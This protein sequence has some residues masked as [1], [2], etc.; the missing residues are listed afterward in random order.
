[1][2]AAGL[3]LMPS[4]W[5]IVLSA[6]ALLGAGPARGAFALAGVAV[7]ALGLALLARAQAPARKDG[8]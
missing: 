3:L 5:I 1:M 7:E 2:K 6:L 4:G 8:E